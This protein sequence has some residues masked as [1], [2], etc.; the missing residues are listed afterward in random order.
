MWPL[1][2]HECTCV[3]CGQ[4]NVSAM[5]QT[6]VSEIHYD[7]SMQRKCLNCGHYWYERPL[8]QAAPEEL[9]KLAESKNADKK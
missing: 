3:K 8:D 2:Q 9:L 1:Y 6:S 7:E 4:N 5:L